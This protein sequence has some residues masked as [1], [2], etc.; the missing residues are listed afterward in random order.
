LSPDQEN[1]TMDK[2]RVKGSADQ[3]MGAVKEVA[4]KL[5][6]D[7]KLQADGKAGKLKGQVENAVGGAKD[8]VR[9]AAGKLD[10]T[11]NTDAVARAG[12]AMSDAVRTRPVGT[13]AVAAGIGAL[14]GALIAR[15]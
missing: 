12:S 11:L 15:V 4:G 2:D 5:T 1:G 6:G 13:L 10:R 9:Q 3:A 7:A 14:L 8:A